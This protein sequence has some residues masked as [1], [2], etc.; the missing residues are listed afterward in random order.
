MRITIFAT[1]AQQGMKQLTTM[2]NELDNLTI[3]W[4]V[5][6]ASK[7]TY[8]DVEATAQ[9]GSNLAKQF[10][11][12][13]PGKTAFAGFLSPEAA[14]TGT[15]VN[16]LDDADVATAKASL[17]EMRKKAAAELA[18]QNLPEEQSKLAKQLLTDLA[19]ILE[20]TVE[21]KKLDG[22]LMLN[23]EPGK[24][25][26]VA[27]NTIVDGAKLDKILKQLVDEVKKDRPVV[28]EMIKLNAETYEGVRF[29]YA[30]R[31]LGRSVM[32]KLFG[33]TLEAV[34]G[35]G[36]D[37]V[38]VAVGHD[39]ARETQ[40]RIGRLESLITTKKCCRCSLL[41]PPGRLPNSLPA[42]LRKTM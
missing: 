11:A 23:L 19:A 29:Q 6:H 8:L 39:A 10:A 42:W 36:D 4:N 1:M 32:T 38:F 40:G 20:K 41:S 17:T 27:G 25:T 5:D 16:K 37:K 21:G 24:A 35:V 2:L 7:T 18:K 14:V 3:G 13:Q 31:P 30:Q 22:G 26:V 12:V 34:F 28:D 15:W 33:D 9:P